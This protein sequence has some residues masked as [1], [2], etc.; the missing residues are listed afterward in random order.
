[1]RLAIATDAW[2]P[3]INGVV[4]SLQETAAA[5]PALGIAVHFVT[6]EGLPSLPLPTYPDIR[7]AITAGPAIGRRL[8]E[9]R[10][11][12]VHIATEGT[13]G[14][15]VRR[16]CL[17]RQLPFTT[18]Y[19]T[20]YPDYVRAR[21]PIP[22]AW[23][24]AWLRHFHGAARRTMV[25]T[26]TMRGELSRWGFANLAL[27]A[28]G[29]DTQQFRPRPAVK[30]GYPGPVMLSVGRLAVEKNLEAFL[31]LDLPGTK[32]VVGDGPQRAELERRFPDAVFLGS[33]TGE[34]LAEI[35]A[36]ADVFVFTSRTDTYGNVMQEALASGLPVAAFPVPGP[37]D[38]VGDPAIACLDEDLARAIETALALDRARCRA[39]AESRSWAA[40][41]RQFADALCPFGATS[42]RAA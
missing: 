22:E 27:W 39:V 7:L 18:S 14:H 12:A 17:T 36:G 19:H 11:D 8:D 16:W 2:S 4:R 13:I 32:L 28:R 21:A 41:A 29:V 33:R 34:A 9:I 38:V 25:P 20:R 35:Y 37:I 24:Y 1:M 6:P 42:S 3:Q 10:P 23:T 30:L 5:L 40:A 26:E 31:A 15:A